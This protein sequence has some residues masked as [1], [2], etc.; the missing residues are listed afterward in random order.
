MI[1]NVKIPTI[2]D[3]QYNQASSYD[4]GTYRILNKASTR[5]NL[6]S[7]FANNKGADMRN[8]NILASICSCRMVGDPKDRFS[9]YGAICEQPSLRRVCIDAQ[10]YQSIHH[11]H[12]KGSDVDEGSR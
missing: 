7:V 2:K 3:P 1:I 6:S 9:R 4:F 11:A 5:A 10:S 8:F 12:I